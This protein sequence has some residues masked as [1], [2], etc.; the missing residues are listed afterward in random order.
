M[1]SLIPENVIE[2]FL[3][4][5]VYENNLVYLDYWSVVHFLSGYVLG[6]VP[7]L[8]RSFWLVFLL[9]VVYEVFEFLFWGVFFRQESFKNIIS[10]VGVGILGWQVAQII[11]IPY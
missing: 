3:N 8:R 7:F 9:L 11:P 2:R 4:T 5:K 10:D 1:V 6:K